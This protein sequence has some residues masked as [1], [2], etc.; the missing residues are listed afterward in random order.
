MKRIAANAETTHQVAA[1]FVPDLKAGSV[2]ALVG[3]LGAGK[4]EFV[5]GLASGL[6]S[7]AVVT[8]PTFTLIHEYLGGRLPLYHMDFYRLSSEDELDEI[9]FDDYLSQAGICAVE[10]A[11]RFPERIPG[12]AIW[13]TLSIAENNERLICW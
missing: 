10:W 6:G 3:D 7:P 8:S 5:K 9:G 12:S 11:N 2:V 1:E 13:V 4:T